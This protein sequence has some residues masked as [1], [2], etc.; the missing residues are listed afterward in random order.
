MNNER[1]IELFDYYGLDTRDELIE[2]LHEQLT[3]MRVLHPITNP[4]IE[5][6][7]QAKERHAQWCREHPTDADKQRDF[8]ENGFC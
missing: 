7:L 1:L 5:A 8:L 3:H 2:H 4:Q 6:D